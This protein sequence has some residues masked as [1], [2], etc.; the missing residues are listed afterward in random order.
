MLFPQPIMLLDAEPVL[1]PLPSTVQ[2]TQ[3]LQSLITQGMVW[4]LATVFW[5]VSE[6]LL[7]A[8]PRIRVPLF[9]ESTRALARTKCSSPLGDPLTTDCKRNSR[10]KRLTRY[11]A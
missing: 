9:R 8:V 10:R 3:R 6:L 1:T 5:V 11:P 2:S 7:P 4:I